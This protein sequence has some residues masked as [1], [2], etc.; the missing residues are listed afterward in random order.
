MAS[1]LLIGTILES[2]NMVD[3]LFYIR[4]HPRCS[5]SE[6]YRNITRNAHTP[7]KMLAL[8][9]MGLLE[10]ID[11]GRSNVMFLSL[12]PKGEEIVELLSRAERLLERGNR[13]YRFIRSALCSVLGWCEP[14][15]DRNS[16]IGSQRCRCISVVS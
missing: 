12:T 2:A 7:E 14:N 3:I 6:I 15:V 5:K 9:D 11:A 4:D 10:I 13:P 16:R 1:R 8:R